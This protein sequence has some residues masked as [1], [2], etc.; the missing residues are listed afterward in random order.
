VAA[1]AIARPMLASLSGNEL[2]ARMMSSV[3][4]PSH[5]VTSFLLGTVDSAFVVFFAVWTAFFL[6]LS[7]RL[8][9]VRR[10]R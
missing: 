7:T 4:V 10:W 8:L 2:F 6:F 1:P 3:D 9:E 5:L